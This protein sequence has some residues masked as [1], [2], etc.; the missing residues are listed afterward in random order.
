METKEQMMPF[1]GLCKYCRSWRKRCWN[2]DHIAKSDLW[3]TDGN[4]WFD[5][6]EGWRWKGI[7]WAKKISGYY[8]SSSL[9]KLWKTFWAESSNAHMTSVLLQKH[10]DENRPVVFY[11]HWRTAGYLQEVELDSAGL[12]T[13]SSREQGLRVGMCDTTIFPFDTTPGDTKASI[14]ILIL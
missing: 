10:D 3:N 1:L 2:D 8:I 6:V 4:V 12:L 7:L 11:S 14:P 13:A 9:T 5:Q